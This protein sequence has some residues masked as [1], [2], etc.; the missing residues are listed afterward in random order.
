MV[1]ELATTGCPEVQQWLLRDGY[2]NN[3]AHEYLACLCAT[4]GKLLAALQAGPVDER[5]LTGAGEILQALL[6]GRESPGPGMHDYPDGAAAALAWLECVQRQQPRRQTVQ[7]ALHALAGV[8]SHAL[9]WPPAQLQQVAAL[10]RSLCAP[11]NRIVT[12]AV[13]RFT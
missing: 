7:A 9:P 10:A 8:E 2:K 4:G 1:R 12:G 6:H 5:L 11:T 13:A 3:F